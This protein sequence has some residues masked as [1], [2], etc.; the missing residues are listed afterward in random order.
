LINSRKDQLKLLL[1]AIEND[2]SIS[3]EL[4][5]RQK[6]HVLL[7]IQKAAQ[8]IGKVVEQGVQIQI[9][10]EQTDREIKEML[11]GL[12]ESRSRI[13]N[14][15]IAQIQIVNRLCEKYGI[16][17]VYQG[18]QERRQQGDFAMELVK[19]YFLNRI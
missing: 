3:E 15:L 12:D 6:I 14:S 13:H 2:Q 5:D 1:M 8:Y 10:E 9:T 17:K 19:Q 11:A 4:K 16:E 7:L 18:G